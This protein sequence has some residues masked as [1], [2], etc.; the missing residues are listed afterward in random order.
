MGMP[1][2]QGSLGGSLVHTFSVVGFDPES[3]D[4][5]VAVQSEFFNVGS[6]VPWAKAKV[7]AIATQSYANVAY[8]KFAF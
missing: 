1:P 6:V 5:G 7:G 2:S 4:L 3:G 8:G